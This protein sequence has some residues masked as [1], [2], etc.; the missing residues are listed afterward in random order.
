MDDAHVILI[1]EP[2]NHLSYS[3]MNMLVHRIQEK[4][5]DRQVLLATHSSYVLNKLG[6]ENLVLLSKAGGMRLGTL[7][8]DTQDYF[9]KL[10]GYDT[11]RL[12]LAKSVILVEGP[13]DSAVSGL[14]WMFTGSFRSKT[15]QT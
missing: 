3:T 4:C 8:G 13:S 6:L 10:S 9:R 12:I 2:E 1:E 5:E 7:D 15:A 11:L 14:T